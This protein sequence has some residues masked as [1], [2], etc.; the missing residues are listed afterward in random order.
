MGLRQSN[1]LIL[2]IYHS[3]DRTNGVGLRHVCLDQ[4]FVE[5]SID[6]TNGVGLRPTTNWTAEALDSIDRTNGVGLRLII[7]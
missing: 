1:P 3:I 2:R 5:N 7:L 6:R 4:N